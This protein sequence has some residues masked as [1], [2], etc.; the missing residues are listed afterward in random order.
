MR[1]GFFFVHFPANV[2]VNPYTASCDRVAADVEEPAGRATLTTIKQRCLPAAGVRDGT[3]QIAGQS[4]FCCQNPSKVNHLTSISR[5]SSAVLG[6]KN[7]SKMSLEWHDRLQ[8][9]GALID[10]QH[11]QLFALCERLPA[12]E[13]SGN[14]ANQRDLHEILNDF[15]VLLSSH[16]AHEEALLEWNRCPDFAAH[17]REHMEIQERLADLLCDCLQSTVDLMALQGILKDYLNRHIIDWDLKDKAFLT[18]SLAAGSSAI[19]AI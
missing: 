14:P 10:K 15:A 5:D 8:V 4:L 3:A 1:L 19:A 16:F 13:S 17:Q 12:Q 6:K 2:S 11:Q 7:G 18:S 9:D